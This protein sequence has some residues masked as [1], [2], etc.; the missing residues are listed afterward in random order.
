[1]RNFFK[2]YPTIQGTKGHGCPREPMFVWLA[3]FAGIHAATFS[4]S[5]VLHT[6]TPSKGSF[7]ILCFQLSTKA[8]VE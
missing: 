2:E 1:M 5:L 4:S 8:I 7:S 6:P 3:I